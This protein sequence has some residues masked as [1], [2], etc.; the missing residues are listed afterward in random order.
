[1]SRPGMDGQT[2]STLSWFRDWVSSHLGGIRHERRVAAIARSLFDVTLPFHHMTRA[3]LRLLKAAA[4]LH[5]VGR[6]VDNEDHPA[7]GARMIRRDRSL[8]LKKRHRRALA[9][10]TLR[11]RGRVPDAENDPALRRVS[12]P[13]KVRLLLA[14]LRAADALDS[15]GLPSPRLSISRRARQ[16]R[17]VCRLSEDT[18]KARRIFS[19]RKKFKLLEEILDCRVEVVVLSRRRLSAVA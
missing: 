14:L 4:Y 15:R 8:P 19:R 5:D 6:S 9:Y 11:H 17:I 18:A 12:D 7:I 13:S 1:M 2:A 16:I 10:M 3:D